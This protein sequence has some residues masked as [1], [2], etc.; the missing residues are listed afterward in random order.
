MGLEDGG[1]VAMVAI[2]FR[3]FVKS[4]EVGVRNVDDAASGPRAA[5]IGEKFSVVCAR[6]TSGRRATTSVAVGEVGGGG[7]GILGGGTGGGLRRARR[8]LKS[9][10]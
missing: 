2:T 4:R 7:R 5:E 6:C 9:A 10:K 1:V 8:H 3:L